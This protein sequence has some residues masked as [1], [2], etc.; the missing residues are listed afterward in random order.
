[1]VSKEFLTFAK[2]KCEDRMSDDR[3][4]R[5]EIK[6][7]HIADRLSSIDSTLVIQHSSLKEHTRRSLA[8]E[9]QV[10]P[11][12]NHVA[13]VSGAVKFLGIMAL[14]ATIATAFLKIT[15]KK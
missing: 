8:L 15:G 14:L 9:K 4:E 11:L 12:R 10:E 1:M 3:L 6:L 2:V 13:M 7:D 5:I